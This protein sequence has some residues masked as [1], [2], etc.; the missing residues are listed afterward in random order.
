MSW[1][2]LYVKCKARSRI[3]NKENAAYEKRMLAF[4]EKKSTPLYSR[5]SIDQQ[6]KW[7]ILHKG[8]GCRSF[9]P[10]PLDIP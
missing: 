8:A 6:Q 10:T 4:S 5:E 1:F 3:L 2:F 9:P 7:R